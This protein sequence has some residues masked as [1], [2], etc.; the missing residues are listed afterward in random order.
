MSPGHR[1]SISRDFRVPPSVS[2][3]SPLRADLS[4]APVL[5]TGAQ[6]GSAAC[7]ESWAAPEPEPEPSGS[8]FVHHFPFP[9]WEGGGGRH[10]QRSSRAEK[11]EWLVVWWDLEVTAATVLHQ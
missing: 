7:P 6:K 2:K 5:E 3:K 8:V 10:T 1:D 4:P 11:E 9:P